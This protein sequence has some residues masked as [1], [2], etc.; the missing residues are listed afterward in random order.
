[1]AAVRVLVVDD[2]AFMRVMISRLLGQDPALEVVGVARDGEEALAQVKALCPDVITLDVEM[3]KMGGLEFLSRLMAYRPTPVVMLSSLTQAGAEIT[4]EALGLG[5]VDFVPK[6]SQAT[7][8]HQVAN[9]LVTKVKRASKAKVTPLPPSREPERLRSPLDSARFAQVTAEVASWDRVLII[10]ASTGGPRALRHVLKAL[11]GDL[12]AAVLIVQHMPPGFTRSLAQHLDQCAALQVR[13]AVAGDRLERGVA[14]VA[15]G[16]YHMI[17]DRDGGIR[18]DQGPAVNG[19]R[20]SVD[21]TLLGAAAVHGG[22]AIAV[23]L[24]GMGHDGTD[25]ARALK[26]AGGIVLAEHESTCVVYGMPRSVI[27]AGLADEVVPLD[28]MAEAII[29]HLNPASAGG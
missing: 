14:L 29:R 18:L 11:P 13:E 15:P 22:R 17:P 9:E 20:P 1:M 24:T 7:A 4:V 19:V 25:G 23:V 5:A 12:P 8:I 10:G 16:G 6:P 26:R 28:Q 3:P 21:V 2:S 27:E